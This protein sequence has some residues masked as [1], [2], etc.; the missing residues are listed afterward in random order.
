M[1]GMAMLFNSSVVLGVSKQVWMYFNVV[2]KEWAW[3]LS[4]WDEKQ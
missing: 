2:T 1:W 3:V 4:G